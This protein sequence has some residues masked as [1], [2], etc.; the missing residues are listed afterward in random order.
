MK[1][2]AH[3]WQE[4]LRFFDSEFQD[5][6][7]RRPTNLINLVSTKMD[8]SNT[9]QGAVL[10]LAS[11]FTQTFCSRLAFGRDVTERLYVY[12]PCVSSAFWLKKW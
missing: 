1:L 9:F 2:V 6:I 12:F 8:A 7:N 10:S 4:K 3:R 11:L 5:I